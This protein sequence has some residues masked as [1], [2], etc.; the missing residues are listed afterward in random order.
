MVRENRVDRIIA[1]IQSKKENKE[2][3]NKNELSPTKDVFRKEVQENVTRSQYI[4]NME[5]KLFLVSQVDND[6]YNKENN[7][8]HMLASSN[9]LF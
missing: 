5:R 8:K 1:K 4:Q 7:Q 6:Q 2:L 9:V 3:H